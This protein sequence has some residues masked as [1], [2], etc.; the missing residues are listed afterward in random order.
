M[1]PLYK[2]ESVWRINTLVLHVGTIEFSCFGAGSSRH[3]VF[4]SRRPG[5]GGCPMVI[6]SLQ[7]NVS[8]VID[9]LAR[10][11][12]Q[13]RH[14]VF[15]FVWLLHYLHGWLDIHVAVIVLA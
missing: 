11:W 15:G 10:H 3:I 4:S 2:R 1:S 6:F 9:P 14:S 12:W 8:K 7:Q 5:G 13:V